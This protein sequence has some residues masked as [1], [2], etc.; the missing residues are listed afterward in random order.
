MSFEL[1]IE[2]YH[3]V[4]FVNVLFSALHRDAV[5]SLS[6]V[7]VCFC[8]HPCFTQDYDCNDIEGKLHNILLTPYLS[9]SPLCVNPTPI[10]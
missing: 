10:M 8:L 1:D 9:H 7:C 5:A 3:Q 2:N 6:C 4:H